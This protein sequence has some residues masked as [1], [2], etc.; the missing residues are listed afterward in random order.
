MSELLWAT[1]PNMSDVIGSATRGNWT[2]TLSIRL[3]YSFLGFFS[4]TFPLVPAFLLSQFV[5]HCVFQV[6][7]PSFYTALQG[8]RS[9]SNL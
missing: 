6:T 3:S 8:S 5:L 1:K 4:S 9:C 2:I 7:C